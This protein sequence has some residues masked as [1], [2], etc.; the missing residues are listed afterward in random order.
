M[1]DDAGTVGSWRAMADALATVVRRHAKHYE[2]EDCWYS[3][4]ASDE[5]C[6]DTRGT[7]CDCG[8]DD[9]LAMLALYDEFLDALAYEQSGRTDG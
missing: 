6:C 5:C 1:T 3:C 8:A 7:D 2:S 9:A 4:P